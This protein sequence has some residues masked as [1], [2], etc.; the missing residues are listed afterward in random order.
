MTEVYTTKRG[1]RLHLQPVGVGAIQTLL[2]T[3]Q[4]MLK[5]FVESGQDVDT[6]SMNFD[7]LPEQE[8]VTL[9]SDFEPLFNYCIGWGVQDDPPVEALNDLKALGVNV[10]TPRLARIK[11][12]RILELD[13]DELGKVM[14]RVLA[15][16]LKGV[17]SAQFIKPEPKQ[18]PEDEVAAL[19]AR[20][21]ELEAGSTEA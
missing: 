12:L 21:A 2:T 16:S 4:A 20:I 15:I 14:G 18:E 3:N 9:V 19:R 11:W 5:L 10:S 17:D 6:A 13:Q 7:Q 8:Q 1:L